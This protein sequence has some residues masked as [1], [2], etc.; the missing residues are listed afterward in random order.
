MQ[1]D[2]VYTPS[3]ADVFQKGKFCKYLD[4]AKI[5]DQLSDKERESMKDKI[6]AANWE[7]M[8][9]IDEAKKREKAK[10]ALQAAWETIQREEKEATF[11]SM[12]EFV[13]EYL[14][15]KN[16][17]Y[18]LVQRLN[19]ASDRNSEVQAHTKKLKLAVL[20][21]E[22]NMEKL[23]EKTKQQE[24]LDKSLQALGSE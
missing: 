15:Y 14:K 19:R 24:L 1:N 21:Q 7:I 17:V 16:T 11:D 10:D 18:T 20:N 4:E 12:N 13:D 5:Y 22:K 23:A 8:S 6:S 9:K 3:N 2:V